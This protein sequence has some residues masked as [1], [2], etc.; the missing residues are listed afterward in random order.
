VN[1]LIDL[2]VK[3]L[4]CRACGCITGRIAARQAVVCESCARKRLRLDRET[5]RFLTDFIEV[6][7]RPTSPIE[8]RKSE[9]SLQPSGAGAE[10]DSI[11]PNRN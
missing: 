7:G 1:T 6:F 2:R 10:T 11:A 5:V 8:I 4:P 3:M 9:T